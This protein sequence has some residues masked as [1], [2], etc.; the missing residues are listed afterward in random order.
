MIKL[1]VDAEEGTKNS[2]LSKDQI[3]DVSLILQGA[4]ST[5]LKCLSSAL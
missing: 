1:A 3:V 2:R 5:H 4:Q